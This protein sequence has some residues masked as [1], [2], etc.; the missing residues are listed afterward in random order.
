MTDN[1]DQLKKELEDTREA[2]LWQSARL[3][4]ANQE[5]DKL[6]NPTFY[7]A[8]KNPPEWVTKALS[9][10][11]RPEYVLYGYATPSGKLYASSLEALSNGEQSWVKVYVNKEDLK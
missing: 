9:D 10:K 4:Q 8:I 5:I 3:V 1:I 11:A 7:D 2:Y 6:K